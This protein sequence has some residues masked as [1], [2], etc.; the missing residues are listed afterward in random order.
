MLPIGGTKKSLS[1]G[2]NTLRDVGRIA[3]RVVIKANNTP[4]PYVKKY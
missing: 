2:Q 3:Y 1:C 4:V